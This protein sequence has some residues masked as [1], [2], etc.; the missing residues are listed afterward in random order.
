MNEKYT[1]DFAESS[2]AVG[3]LEPII[4][5]LNENGSIMQSQMHIDD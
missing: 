2:N 5:R 4:G 1:I 3:I